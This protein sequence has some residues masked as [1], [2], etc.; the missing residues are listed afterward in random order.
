MLI[1]L[2]MLM[3]V[4]LGAL[5]AFPSALSS[6]I[7]MALAGASFGAT[8]AVYPITI[9]AYYGVSQLARVYGRI[10]LA[11]GVAGL[12]APYL[13]G[14][15]YDLEGNY[16]LALMIAAAMAILSVLVN[17]LLPRLGNTR[18]AAQAQA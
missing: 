1:G 4:A 2:G 5:V 6:V 7:V 15:L 9:P 3:A 12:L 13:A 18:A 10:M 8:A 16:T 14:A 17:T 11:Y